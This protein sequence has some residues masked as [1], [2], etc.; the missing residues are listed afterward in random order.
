MGVPAPRPDE[1]TP[2]ILVS[3]SRLF[4]ECLECRL[5]GSRRFRVAAAFDGLAPALRESSAHRAELLLIDGTSVGEEDLERLRGHGEGNPK[6]VILGLARG[7]R[8]L[9]RYVDAGVSGYLLRDAPLAELT[10]ALEA[11][12]RGERV[13]GGRVARYLVERLGRLGRREQERE[14]MGALRLTP[15]QMEVLRLIAEGLGNDQIADRLG[16]SPYTVKNHVHNILECLGVSD[17][18]EAVAYAYRRRW[19]V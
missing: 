12:L 11:V 10:E 17:R 6:T 15:R 16:L 3:R 18:T 1:A 9:H 19:L 5:A 14:A 7:A 13:C 2:L 4:R 8:E